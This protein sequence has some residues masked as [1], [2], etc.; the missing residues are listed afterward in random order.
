MGDS[1]VYYGRIG[2]LGRDNYHR[3]QVEI[4]NALRSHGLWLYATGIE[5]VVAEPADPNAGDY[6]AKMKAF[7][8][9]DKNDAKARNIIIATLNEETFNHVHDCVT[10][11]KML[12]RIRE[13]RDPKTTDTLMTGIMAFFAE[14]WRDDDSVASFMARLSVSAGKVNSCGDDVKMD[15]RF[16]IAKTLLALPPKFATFVQSWHL[17]AKEPKLSEF[18]EKL[19]NA[20]R[21]LQESDRF[22]EGSSGEALYAKSK[23]RKKAYDKSKFEGECFNCHKRGHRKADCPDQ[24]RNVSKRKDSKRE[25]D[26]ESKTGDSV[27]SV[28]TALTSQD[29]SSIIAD[30]GASRHLTGNISWFRTLRKLDKP[31]VFRSANGN[32]T[33]SHVGDIDVQVSVDGSDWKSYTW[34][35]VFFVPGLEM[36]LFSTTW[37]EDKGFGF[38]HENGKMS[39]TRDVKTIMG[40]IRNGSSYTPFMRVIPPL[41]NAMAAQK[42]D[43]RSR[44][45]ESDKISRVF[46]RERGVVKRV[47]DIQVKDAGRREVF[48]PFPEVTEERIIDGSG[49]ID[50]EEAAIESTSELAAAETKLDEIVDVEEILIPTPKE[51]RRPQRSKNKPNAIPTQTSMELRS[52]RFAL[53]VM[54]KALDQFGKE[55]FW[56]NTYHR[57]GTS[58]IS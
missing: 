36:T 6:K 58:R 39:L 23:D 52:K 21:G 51:R 56:S 32:I 4:T 54:A 35:D 12:D 46:N 5:P 15:D 30:S 9:F 16:T 55:S 40:G 25:D 41:E 57:I 45:E 50:S 47:S 29:T 20:E 37:M 34:S 13:L 10:S 27:L 53:N 26:D 42:F 18:R 44:K 17:V 14:T 8:E 31:L 33:A 7:L 1:N 2:A 49:I 19:L 43:A 3:W 48:M 28:M 38:R 22:S 24:K 11:K